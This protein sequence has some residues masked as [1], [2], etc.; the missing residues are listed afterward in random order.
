MNKQ[1]ALLLRLL[2]TTIVLYALGAFFYAAPE[3]IGKDFFD[4]AD[5]RQTEDEYVSLLQRYVL[6]PPNK[7]EMLKSLSV[8]NEEIDYYRNYYGTE[9][10]QILNVQ[11]QYE[12]KINDAKNVESPNEAYI[13]ALIAERDQKIAEI[14]KNFADEQAVMDK[15][16]ALKKEAVEKYFAQYNENKQNF[17]NS[18]SYFGY[19][20]T[21]EATGD[22]LVKEIKGTPIRRVEKTLRPDVNA[23]FNVFDFEHLVG[24]MDQE[25]KVVTSTDEYTGT[26]ML[27]KNYINSSGLGWNYKYF[28][29][30]KWFNIALWAIGLGAFLLLMTKFKWSTRL[31]EPFEK[32]FE[33]IKT[34]PI[35][36]LMAIEV[37]L[38]L[39][40]IAAFD[41][42]SNLIRN[43]AYSGRYIISLSFVIEFIFG[44]LIRV[45]LVGVTVFLGWSIVKLFKEKDS[46][47][48][49]KHSFSYRFTELVQNLFLNRSI[50]IQTLFM[51]A[52]FFLGGFGFIIGMS[53]MELFLLYA[54][55][56]FF[57]LVPT[58]FVYLWRMGYLNK[59][60]KHT[61]AMAEG[62]L[63]QP[64][65]VKG[66]SPLAKHA[67]NLNALQEGVRKSVTEQAKSERLKT[68]LITNVSHDLR[69]PLTS[70]ITYTDLLKNPDLTE[71]ERQKY[72]SILDQKAERLK[73]LI[74]DLFEVSKM[75]SGNIELV[76]QR[77]DIAQLIQ[78]IAGEHVSDFEDNNLDLRI[79]IVSNP[80]F[81]Y[82]DGQKLWRV[83]DNLLNN[84][85]KYSLP[86]TRVYMDLR[87]EQG[88][89]ILTVKNVSKYELDGDAN[90]L[91]ERFKRADTARHT[92]GSGLGLAIATSI[93]HLHGGTLDISADGDLFKVTVVLPC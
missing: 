28:V 16:M 61:E 65:K 59:I 71:E 51:F 42:G 53:R 81:A 21:N 27:S 22:E 72:V 82:V 80:L 35:D 25:I 62:R 66:N 44:V 49:W 29:M 48:L 10:E 50:G 63:T 7:E 92:E 60:I 70:I 24:L 43:I 46:H 54:F 91:T 86:S 34:K 77:V 13:N 58:T 17:L 1:T 69:T 89:A 26:I 56:F 11:E 3:I 37:V 93:V 18:Y 39:L 55:L 12:E 87:E 4:S 31:F 5:Y 52:V 33:K 15:I 83:C 20:L 8:S 78:Q 64:I 68:E 19:S 45:A 57:I 14:Q 67:E 88:K 75:A 30:T 76:K 23:S 85:R 6:Y 36:V 38:I 90:E 73:V 47:T 2:L 41:S 84:A 32:Y 40:T 9:T 74:E 79:T